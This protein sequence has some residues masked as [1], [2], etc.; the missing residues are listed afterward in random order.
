MK[1]W[2]IS[3][4]LSND[5]AEWPGDEPCCFR[6]TRQKAKGESVNL[7]AISMSVHNGTH[8]DAQFHF[9]TNGESIEKAPLETYLGRATVVDLAQAFLDSKE[10]HLITIEDLRPSAEAIA[11]TSRLLVKTGRWSD[12]AVFPNQIPVIAADVPAWLQKNGV[13][14][15]GMDLPSVDEIDS[16]SL[17]NHHA[18]ARAGIAIVESLDLSDVASGIYQFAAPPLKIAGGDGAPMRAILWRE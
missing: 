17:Q 10:K 6:L 3:R 5:L 13:K 8:A 2:D 1:I 18:L 4:T 14:L 16:K 11:A 12:S 15:L 9:D 7:G